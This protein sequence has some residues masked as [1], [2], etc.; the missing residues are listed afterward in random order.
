MLQINIVPKVK[1]QREIDKS[2]KHVETQRGKNLTCLRTICTKTCNFWA[3][4][5]RILQSASRSHVN[6]KSCITSTK[7]SLEV[8]YKLLAKL[9]PLRSKNKPILC[10]FFFLFIPSFISH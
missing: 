9:K 3:L 6:S 7:K 8:V 2:Q 1:Y 10:L 4:A 5:D